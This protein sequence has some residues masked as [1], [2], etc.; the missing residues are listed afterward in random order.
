VADGARLGDADRD[1]L[2][3]L[4]GRHYAE[5]R[6]DADELSRRLDAVYGA[7][8]RGDAAGALADLPVLAPAQPPRR[9]WGRRHAEADRPEPTWLPTTERFVDPSTDRVMR[10]WLEPGSGARHYVAES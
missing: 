1:A 9:R 7:T 6:L 4:L 3:Q 5:G 10:V 2:A 8:H